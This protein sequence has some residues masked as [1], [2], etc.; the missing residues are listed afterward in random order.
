[1]FSLSLYWTLC[2]MMALVQP[3]EMGLV[4]WACLTQAHETK[5]C[6][7]YFDRLHLDFALVTIMLE[8]LFWLF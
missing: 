3:P 6:P 1:M 7:H 8:H 5:S 4:I 2:V